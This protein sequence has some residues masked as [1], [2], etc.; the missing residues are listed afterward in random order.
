[1]ATVAG[2][3]VAFLRG[4]AVVF[5]EARRLGRLIRRDPLAVV[6]LGIVAVFVAAAVLAPVLAPYPNEGRGTSNLSRILQPPSPAHP[7]GTDELGR[8]LLSRVLF[9]ATLAFQV[10]VAVVLLAFLVG[11]PLGVI[12][13]YYRGFV[14]EAIMRVTDMF[15]A[16]PPIL[17][18]LVIAAALGRGSGAVIVA[19]AISFWPWYTRLVHGQVLH[20]RSQPFV[21]AAVALGLPRRRIVFRHVFPNALAP[22]TIQAS[23]DVG[24]AILAAAALNFLGLGPQP[25]T[26]DWGV[27]VN[28]AYATGNFAT[29]WWYATFPGLAIFVVVLAFN[30]IGDSTREI[31]DPKLRRR[32]LL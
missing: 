5:E 7:F 23:M 24:S 9:G 17:L 26:P 18:A 13:G 22:A 15:L 14:E 11:A 21:E 10:G 12:A 29:F 2:R 20:I 30:L 3:W 6:G 16:F 1:M 8:D 32:R 31:L 28:T 19:I 4:H 27:M 25:P